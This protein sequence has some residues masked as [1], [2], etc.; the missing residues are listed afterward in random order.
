MIKNFIENNNFKYYKEASLKNFNTYKIDIKCKYLVFPKTREELIKLIKYLKE[1]KY[2]F[3]V[4][5]N[6]SNVIF[7]GD[8]YDG[9]VVKLDNFKKLTIDDDVVTVEAGYSLIKL[10]LDVSLEGLSGLEFA[11]GIPGSIASSVAMNAG[12][13]NDSL[14][15][16]VID[17]EVLTPNYEI[18]TM[19][20]SQLDFKYRHSFFKDNKDYIIIS[21]RLQ[22]S[23]G[24]KKE[25]LDLISQRRIRRIESQPLNYPSAGSVFRNPEGMHSGALIEKCGLKG[26]KLG[27]AQVSCK[28]A[29]FIVNYDNATGKDI[30]ALINK[31]KKEVKKK[32]HVDLKLEQIIID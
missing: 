1:N 14:S 32:Y 30:V 19:T 5:G 28:H 20:N 13:Y 7:A 10:A 12:A 9:I 17:V 29:N 3:I 22:L 18:I 8:Y 31:V 15:E 24:N 16:I 23:H 25:I 2:K 26:Y 27:G 4:L 21:C 11:S 6:G